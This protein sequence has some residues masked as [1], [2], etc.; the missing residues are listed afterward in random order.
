MLLDW[1]EKNTNTAEFQSWVGD[2]DAETKKMCRAYVKSKGYLS[3]LDVAAGLCVDYFGYKEEYPQL[4]YSAVEMTKPFVEWAAVRGVD[5]TRGDIEALPFPD[6]TFEVV[7]GRHI[8]EH[9]HYYDIAL[10]EMI[11]VAKYEV[12]VV[13]FL[14][15]NH[16]GDLIRFRAG[17]FEAIDPGYTD[18]KIIVPQET[19]NG[20]FHNVYRQ[21]GIEDLALSTGRVESL[22]WEELPEEKILHLNLREKA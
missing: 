17:K 6:K 11:R 7:Y 22:W 9:L 14:K 8:L 12:I 16:T 21:K 5:V 10:K 15:P 18:G 4:A 1:W 20:V 3:L 2:K 19:A 13:F